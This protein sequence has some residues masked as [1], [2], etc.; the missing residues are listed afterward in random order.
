MTFNARCDSLR[1]GRDTVVRAA[2]L[3]EGR[4]RVPLRDA[5]LRI[6]ACNMEKGQYKRGSGSS[7]RT[8]SFAEPVRALILYERR[9]AEIPR[10][11]GVQSYFAGDVAF[12]PIFDSLYP[13]NLVSQTHGVDVHWEIQL[14]HDAYV[15]QEIVG[16]CDR[17]VLQDFYAP[18]PADIASAPL[19]ADF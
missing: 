10:G 17:L 9:V 1:I 7:E 6:V 16:G 19:P 13:P 14:L 2:D 5:T 3:F 11:A 12:G 18:R 8:V 4:S 15:D